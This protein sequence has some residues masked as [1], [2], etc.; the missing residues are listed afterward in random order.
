[1]L[2]RANGWSLGTIVEHEGNGAPQING[3]RLPKLAVLRNG[4][5]NGAERGQP[6]PRESSNVPSS[7]CPSALNV[8]VHEKKTGQIRTKTAVPKTWTTPTQQLALSQ[9][10][11]VS[12]LLR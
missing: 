10:Q 4:S 12:G 2:M 1:M 9:I 3:D 5:T 8:Q 11:P 6:C 7:T